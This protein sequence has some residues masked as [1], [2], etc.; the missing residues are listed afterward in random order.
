MNDVSLN[1]FT[2]TPTPSARIYKNL[3]NIYNISPYT[4]D[5][6][7]GFLA[8]D[9]SDNLYGWGYNKANANA[10]NLLG[11]NFTTASTAQH[12]YL[13]E[14]LITSANANNAALDISGVLDFWTNP[15]TDNGVNIIKT[16]K[17]PIEDN[18]INYYYTGVN[19]GGQA[20]NGNIAAIV[21]TKITQTPF[22]GNYT[23]LNI[24]FGSGIDVNTNF[25]TAINNSTGEYSLWATG[26]NN[27]GTCGIGNTTTPLTSWT[28]VPFFS[29]KVKNIKDIY[30]DNTS[31]LDSRTFI[32]LNDG[33]MYFA[34]KATYFMMP[35]L[36]TNYLYFTQMSIP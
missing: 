29:N 8:L 20:G 35:S 36:N 30:S 1:N 11:I 17:G 32:L 2:I 3:S 5:S 9:T 25:V 34:G 15:N 33:T 27:V 22:D 14:N 13:A 6:I 7:G 16:F 12:L 19:S 31:G 10:Y 26:L 4:E 28:R 18:I 21:W 23:I 24:Y